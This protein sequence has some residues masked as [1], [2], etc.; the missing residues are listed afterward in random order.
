MRFVEVANPR[1]GSD[2]EAA[3]G[4][5]GV[6][7]RTGVTYAWTEAARQGVERHAASSGIEIAGLL[8]GRVWSGEVGTLVL[9]EEALP[10]D[11]HVERSSV[12]VTFR[13]EAWDVLSRELDRRSPQTVVVGW[14]H[15]HP[16]LG[17][18]FS[19]TDRDTQHG[20]FRADWQ[21]GVVVDPHRDE[22]AAFRGPEA[23]TVDPAD[24]VSNVR[25]ELPGSATPQAA[26]SALPSRAVP[27]GRPWR[28]RMGALLLLGLAI[29]AL[30]KLPRWRR[31]GR[32]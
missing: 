8:A 7:L 10:A 16:N 18:F 9:V 27:P 4:K 24:F 17:A 2:P 32:L 30:V 23:R 26:T 13:P 31:G 25:L 19:G 29:V 14:Y 1:I 12:H 5:L 21:I 20:A 6:Q 11:Q 22:I 15:S 3:A 28:R